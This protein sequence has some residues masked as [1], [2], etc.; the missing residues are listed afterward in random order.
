[1]YTIRE[2]GEK[3]LLIIEVSGG[4]RTEEALRAISQS[5]TLAEASG[6]RA[7]RCDIR[8]LTKGPAGLLMLAAS[9]ALR[10]QPGMRVA[11]VGTERQ[12]RIASRLAT[13]SGL[14]D[15]MKAFDADHDAEGW[16]RPALA[17]V[18]GLIP[19]TTRRHAE[20]L[21]GISAGADAKTSAMQEA[22]V[23]ALGL[24]PTR[25]AAGRP[26]ATEVDEG[27]EMPQQKRANPAA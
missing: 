27:A 4:M 26:P 16:L 1:M 22:P 7:I 23:R 18:V 15:G 14:R 2:D 12:L 25:P 5:F 8:D 17:P 24:L 9:V 21:L 20:A 11:V 19:S 13:F 6:I 10:H 3:K